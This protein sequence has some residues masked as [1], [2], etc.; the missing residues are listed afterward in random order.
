MKIRSSRTPDKCCPLHLLLPILIE[1][2]GQRERTFARNL[3]TPSLECRC[4]CEPHS[5]AVERSS[6]GQPVD[7]EEV[8]HSAVRKSEPHHRLRLLGNR[9]LRSIGTEPS[10]WKVEETWI[11]QDFRRRHNGVS[12]ADVN[13][14]GDP[15]VAE[16]G[17]QL[18]AH[19]AVLLVLTDC[20][21]LNALRQERQAVLRRLDGTQRHEH[22]LESFRGGVAKAEE[23]DVLRRSNRL[24]EPQQEQSCAL[25]DEP[26]GKLR[27]RQAIQEALTAESS[28]RE[29][30]LDAEHAAALHKSSLNRRD[31]V[32]GTAALHRTIVS[33]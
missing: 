26:V 17:H 18:G 15:H 4:N 20:F 6:F 8:L 28:K 1:V 10:A 19:A 12:R 23:I 2:A 21:D 27:L 24:T 7:V 9:G 31:G 22:T 33:R 16:H 25:E 14:K 30:M 5:L 13:L 11:V 29:L 3:D 32:L